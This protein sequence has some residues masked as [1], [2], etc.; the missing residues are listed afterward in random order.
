MDEI[1][2]ILTPEGRATGKTCLK[3]VA[4]QYGYFHKTVHIWF[5]KDDGKILLQKRAASKKVFPNLWDVSVAGHVETKETIEKA[6]IR[7]IEEE[8]GLQVSINELDK[9]GIWK[10]EEQHPG[11]IF[12]NEFHHV[13]LVQL[14]T[15]ISKLVLQ[16][17]EVSDIQL[18]DLSILE[19]TEKYGIFLVPHALEYYQL[20]SNSITKRL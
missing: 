4:H 17:H 13:F 12:D 9:I 15:H 19:H 3:S 6:A 18:F 5:Y 20:I 11:G 2:D 14:K 1:I 8:I 16:K 7:E 10:S